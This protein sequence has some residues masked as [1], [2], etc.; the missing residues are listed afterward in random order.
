MG[1]T[2]T[3]LNLTGVR[4]LPLI[5]QTEGAE[6][7]LACLAMI[8]S[9]YGY[10]T[11]LPSLRQK[12]PISLKGITMREMK[13]IAAKIGLGARALRCE[14]E[15]LN[16]LRT[17]C[18]LHWDMKHFVVL[19]KVQG[20]K[21]WLH[22][23]ALGLRICKERDIS[24]GFTGIALELSPTPKF[25]KKRERQPVR[26]S[27]LIHWTPGTFSTLAQG[28]ILSLLL[29]LFLLANPFYLQIVIDNVIVKGDKDLLIG[30]AI[31]FGLLCLFNALAGALRG[32]ILQFLGSV[33]SFDMEARL[34]HHLLYLPLDFFQKRQIGDLVQR[35][36]ALEAIKQMIL[37]G[38][39][40]ALLDGILT[41][42]TLSLMMVYNI[43]LSLIAIGAFIV[44]MSIRLGLL[45]ITRQFATDA[46]VAEARE[47]TNFLE[48]IR[49]IQTI[50]VCGGEVTRQSKWRNLFAGRINA[51]IKTGNLSIFAQQL[52]TLFSGLADV[53][54][55]YLAA[56]NAIAGTMTVGTILAFMAYRGQFNLRAIALLEQIINFRLLDVQLD[57]VGD[58][59][60]AARE[61][62]AEVGRAADLEI[63]GRI[64]LIG[65]CFRYA[66]SEPE[67]LKDVDVL[68]APGDF[69]TIVGPSGEGKSTLLKIMI[70]LLQATTGD[71]LIDG[72]AISSMA[73]DL[74]RQQLGVVM[75]EDQ[76]L[77]GTIAENIALFD[78]KPDMERVRE[79]AQAAM[80]DVE[81]MS[82]PMQY[83]SLVGDMGTSLSS[84]QKQRVLI[85]RALY[86]RPK[87]LILDEGMAHIDPAGAE[88]ITRMLR[89]LAITRIVVAHTS[90]LVDA[91]DRVL[92]LKSGKLSEIRSVREQSRRV[93]DLE[94]IAT[95]TVPA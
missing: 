25:Q 12:F 85:A 35:F 86:R 77:G 11:D 21:I 87:I 70:G 46:I 6:C 76:L 38:S 71:T 84:G 28:I 50:K 59:A 61:P 4:R 5:R 18:I 2:E 27:N 29:E 32:V 57:R 33:F 91:A 10:D 26:L 89:S 83:N 14:P 72:T 94:S 17:P 39:I 81:I 41:V 67:I 42:F 90:N 52:S 22:D 95:R 19:R 68:I 47:Q 30:A 24:E 60:L 7:G 48:T 45:P 80:I 64:E 88:A 63:E 3:L 23:P 69:V 92:E 53:L 13:E 55:L 9:W 93:S 51:S 40:A 44:F 8:A 79:C 37:S 78:E 56:Q 54:V 16:Q 73:T 43:K 62:G 49:A 75:Q 58:I 34:F 66:P 1:N 15:H 36:H 74:L 20:S 65:M 31:A 82:F